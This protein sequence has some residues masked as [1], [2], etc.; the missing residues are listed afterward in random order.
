[1][2]L[3]IATPNTIPTATPSTAPK[4]ATMADS[5]STMRRVCPREHPHGA[6]E[7]DLPGPLEDGERQG[8]RDAQQGDEQG[9]A[10]ETVHGD[11]EAVELGLLVGLVGGPV[12]QLHR[13]VG[14]EDLLDR[15][16]SCLGADPWGELREGEHV[17]GAG[18]V[19]AA[20]QVHV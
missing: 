15:R 8:V 12:I 13:G 20:E 10:Q 17:E 6:E 5:T 14:R 2:A 18:G 1:M 11:E 9:Q 16:T 3:A 4:I 19:L 7:P